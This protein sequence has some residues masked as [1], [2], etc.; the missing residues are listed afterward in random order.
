LKKRAQRIN[1]HKKQKKMRVSGTALESRINVRGARQAGDAYRGREPQDRRM[2]VNEGTGRRRKCK[3]VK[4][5][6]LKVTMV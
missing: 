2:H 1:K 6:R 5:T 3:R 4:H